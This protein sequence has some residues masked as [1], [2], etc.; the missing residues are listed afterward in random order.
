VNLLQRMS[1]SGAA[2]SSRF[3]IDDLAKAL[4]VFSFGGSTYA[5]GGAGLKQS[6]SGSQILPIG[7]GF[8]SY[9]NAV[10]SCPPAFGAQLVRSQVL[11]QASF[12]FRNR[13]FTKTP[14]RVFTNTA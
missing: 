6:M 13:R 9:V 1:R 5:T 14:G 8:S 11:S 7:H 4:S 2:T 10:K 12:V 3:S